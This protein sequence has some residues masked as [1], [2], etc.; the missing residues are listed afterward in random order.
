[1]TTTFKAVCWTSEG[2]ITFTKLIDLPCVAF[3]GLKLALG[4]ENTQE[5]VNV[6]YNEDTGEITAILNHDRRWKT[7]DEAREV[8]TGWSEVTE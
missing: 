6:V 8:Y 1:M 5:V 7:K 2:P 3:H 4:S